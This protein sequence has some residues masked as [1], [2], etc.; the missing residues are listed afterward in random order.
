MLFNVPFPFLFLSLLLPS[1]PSSSSS[2]T[3]FELA[4]LV[5]SPAATTAAGTVKLKLTA[6]NTDTTRSGACVVQ[7]YFRDPFALP[8]RISSIQLVRFQKVCGWERGEAPGG[9]VV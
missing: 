6:T 3:Q 9:A 5:V 8:V 2:Y 4:G 1:T 7:I